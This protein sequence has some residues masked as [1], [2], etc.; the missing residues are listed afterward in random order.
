M[1]HDI[2]STARVAEAL[3]IQSE[4][5]DDPDEVAPAL[6]RALKA[7]DGGRPY[8]LEVICSKYPVYGEWIRG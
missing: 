1:G 5:V 6:K 3:G 2:Q 4:R 7:N 8:F